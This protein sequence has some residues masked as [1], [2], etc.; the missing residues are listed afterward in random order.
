MSTCSHVGFIEAVV[1]R[2]C[3]GFSGRP[4]AVHRSMCVFFL[5]GSR[6]AALAQEF[7]PR[8]VVRPATKQLSLRRCVR[9]SPEDVCR[10]ERCS[11]TSKSDQVKLMFMFKSY[12][13]LE[14]VR[15]G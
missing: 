6:H 15:E 1:L 4:N 2:T 7:W 8:F 12:L 11:T 3:L 13:L 9:P 14:R 10:L 5:S